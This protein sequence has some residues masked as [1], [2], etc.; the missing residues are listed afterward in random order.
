MG[1][2]MLRHHQPARAVSY[3]SPY[4][5]ES[6]SRIGRSS[7][8]ARAVSNTSLNECHCWRSNRYHD[9]ISAATKTESRSAL[10]VAGIGGTEQL[11][12][13]P[14]APTLHPREHCGELTDP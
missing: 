11:T 5:S 14:I 3:I 7:G 6:S 2:V 12:S 1:L 9:A 13:L 10:G 8:L 4:C